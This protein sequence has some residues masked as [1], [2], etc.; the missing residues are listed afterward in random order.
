MMKKTLVAMA[1][2]AAT[3]SGS[4][5][6]WTPNG[7]GGTLELGGTLTP[8]PAPTPWEVLTGAAVSNLDAS[9]KVGDKTVDIPVTTPIT[10]LGIRTVTNKAFPGQLGINPQVDFKGAIDTAQFTNG[11]TTL[12]LDIKD[13]ASAKIGQMTAPLS[14]AGVSTELAPRNGQLSVYAERAGSAYWGGV[15]TLEA[16]AVNTG[17]AAKALMDSINPEFTANYDSRGLVDKGVSNIN[18]NN[19]NTSFTSAYGSGIVAGQAIK[20][21]LDAPATDDVINWKASLP[22]TVSYQ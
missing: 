3:V 6:A 1:L 21:T 4:A 8:P 13:A 11:V 14:V 7:I 16:G 19:G 10:V 5:M 20:L 17:T 12:T 9:I 2:V 15:S 18:F 22:I